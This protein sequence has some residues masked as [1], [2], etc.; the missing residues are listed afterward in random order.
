MNILECRFFELI[1]W[2]MYVSPDEYER[3]MN[4]VVDA[5]GDDPAGNVAG[6][7]AAMVVDANG[8]QRDSPMM[9]ADAPAD[10]PV[11]APAA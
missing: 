2:R 9:D 4:S 1:G 8:G 6:G 10:A 7:L 5:T 3:Y 11:D